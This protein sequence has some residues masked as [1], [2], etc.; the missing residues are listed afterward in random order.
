MRGPK[1]TFRRY[2]KPF[3]QIWSNE[4]A[5]SS[6]YSLETDFV[7]WKRRGYSP[8]RVLKRKRVH[9]EKM[10]REYERFY[11]EPLQA[12]RRL[13]FIVVRKPMITGNDE[14]YLYFFK[15]QSEIG[16]IEKK[17]LVSSIM[18]E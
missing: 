5:L 16:L 1:V 17:A 11:R 3:D 4:V 12:G 6:F 14:I 9:I 7:T 13:H 18:A 8:F 2:H 15:F 10:E